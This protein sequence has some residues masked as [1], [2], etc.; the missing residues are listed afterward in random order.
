MISNDNQ[1][2]QSEAYDDDFTEERY[3]LL[4]T[5][6]KVSYRFVTYDSIPWN[7]RFILWR[8]D[9]DY[10]INRAA[11]LAC[12]EAEE[13][14]TATYFVNPCSEYYNPFEPGQARLL[15]FILGLGHRLGLHFDAAFHGVADEAMLISRV[16]QETRW[17][18]EA[19]G[20]RP[21]AL[22]FH[23]PG[24]DHLQFDSDHYDGLVNCYSQRFK[25]KVPYCSDSNGY[26]RFRRLHNVLTEGTDQCLQVLTHPG[27]WQCKPMPPRKRI[28]RSVYGRAYA[29]I[30]MYDALLAD[31]GRVNHAGL[32]ESLRFL[33]PLNSRVFDLCDYL[34]NQGYLSSLFVELWRL[35]ER[36]INQFCKAVFR[37]EWRVSASEVNAFFEDRSLAID[38][39]RLFK[40]VFDNSWL[41]LTDFDDRQYKDWLALRNNLIHGRSTAT[42]EKLEEG[43]LF[44][45]RAIEAMVKWGQSQPMAYDGIRHLGSIGIPT[46]KTADGSLT[47]RLEEIADEVPGFPGK[48]WER[49]KA[50]MQKVGAGLATG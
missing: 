15:K 29:G 22:S 25:T 28:F 10:S 14:V 44:L 21:D 7:S 6:A 20:A 49:F 34:W 45:C 37:K 36:Q 48:R 26:W 23:N 24:A 42:R 1:P 5:T 39:W 33:Q 46:Y 17:L 41:Q 9:L 18:E 12:I 13:G 11:A 32:T 2:K 3:R 16:T 40:A 35:H 4:L 31:N 38:G 8:H 27:L 30:R 19:F 47:D 50:E 43:C